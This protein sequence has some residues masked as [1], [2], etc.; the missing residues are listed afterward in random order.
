MELLSD[1]LSIIIVIILSTILTISIWQFRLVKQ[2][3]RVQSV[4]QIYSKLIEARLNLERTPAFTKM[5]QDSPLFL[6]RFKLVDNPD[7]YYIIVA[8]LDLFEFLHSMNKSKMID[9]DLWFRP[10]EMMK[11]IMTIPKFKKIWD[12]T[13]N[14]HE[15]NF[16]K[17]VDSVLIRTIK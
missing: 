2:E 9:S 14:S 8:F 17:Y 11:S 7:E 15:I 10:E 16:V 4:H 1:Y 5:A 3:L 6:E 13:K 12:E